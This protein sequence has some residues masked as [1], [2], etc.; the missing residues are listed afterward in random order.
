MALTISVVWVKRKSEVSFIELEKVLG[1]SHKDGNE[2][3]T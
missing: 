2:S 3:S 1:N